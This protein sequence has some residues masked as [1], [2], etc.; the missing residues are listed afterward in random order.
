MFMTATPCL[1]EKA[2]RREHKPA[3]GD[4]PFWVR[5]AR[6][7]LSLDGLREAAR[8]VADR[9]DLTA[10]FVQLDMLIGARLGTRPARHLSSRQAIA[11]ALGTP[12]DEQRLNLFERV[13]GQ[14]RVYPFA[15]LD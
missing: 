7:E 1:L 6:G 2:A 9:L 14:L 15:E 10:Q 5:P 8:E 4:R 12:Y 13:A 11:R 3:S